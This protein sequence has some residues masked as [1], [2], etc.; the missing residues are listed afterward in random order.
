MRCS[1]CTAWRTGRRRDH[2]YVNRS[3]GPAAHLA[4]RTPRLAATALQLISDAALSAGMGDHRGAVAH[5]HRSGGGGACCAARVALDYGAAR[6]QLRRS[7]SQGPRQG[8]ISLFAPGLLLMLR[9]L[10]LRHSAARPAGG[11]VSESRAHPA[12]NCEHET[13][14]YVEDFMPLCLTLQS[15]PDR[16]PDAARA[17]AVACAC[18]TESAC[19]PLL[20]SVAWPPL[21]R[22]HSSGGSSDIKRLGPA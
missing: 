12:M 10:C 5:G 15:G 13:C 6:A 16:G 4:E 1:P 9:R 3:R 20:S 7:R 8:E 18:T 19:T 2:G 22:G 17:H 21:K 14:S 11:S